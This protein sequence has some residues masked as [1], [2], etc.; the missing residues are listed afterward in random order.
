MGGP[1]DGREQSYRQCADSVLI[2]ASPN[3]RFCSPSPLPE[4]LCEYP[5]ENTHG[6]RRELQGSLMTARADQ[7]SAPTCHREGCSSKG[8]RCLSAARPRRHYR[9]RELDVGRLCKW[10]QGR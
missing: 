8:R 6:I 2:C 4:R 5:E 3:L 9:N 7:C 1:I 10:V